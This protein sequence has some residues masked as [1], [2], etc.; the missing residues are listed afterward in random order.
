MPWFDARKLCIDL[1]SDFQL[2]SPEAFSWISVQCQRWFDSLQ[3]RGIVPKDRVLAELSGFPGTSPR[4][5]ILTQDGK[6]GSGPNF[7]MIWVQLSR[8]DEGKICFR[9]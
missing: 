2:N 8:V 9:L 5:F 7:M 6:L 4:F 1:P 3:R